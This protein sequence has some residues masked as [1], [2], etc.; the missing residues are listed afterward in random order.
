[1]VRKK[2]CAID[3]SRW[4]TSDVNIP[5]D[6]DRRIDDLLDYDQGRIP[7]RLW[8]DSSC[9]KAK[10]NARRAE[11]DFRKWQ[12]KLN[13]TCKEC[14]DPSIR[15]AAK[16]E[17]DA[18]RIE[19]I[20]RVHELRTL[21]RRKELASRIE[22]RNQ[23]LSMQGSKRFWQQVAVIDTKYIAEQLNKL[24]NT[25][26]VACSLSAFEHHLRSIACPPTCT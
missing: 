19:Y 1:M 9:D 24:T 7:R 21:E 15:A 13:Q 20:H 5:V 10:Y 12:C 2:Y 16:A 18:K 3:V 26:S 8:W 25:S 22:K 14:I 23:L 11:Y 4:G 6:R 17:A